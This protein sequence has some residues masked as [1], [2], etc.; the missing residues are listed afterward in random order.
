MAD[1]QLRWIVICAAVLGALG[2]VASLV[3]GYPDYAT[4]IAVGTVIALANLWVLIRLVQRMV[5]AGKAGSSA[6]LFLLKMLLLGGVLFACF[7][8]IP[9][10]T[11]GFTLGLSVIVIAVTLSAI[12]GPVPVD[13]AKDDGKAV[14]TE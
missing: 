6:G 5:H 3:A 13:P 9:M 4:G 12:F 8:L 2:V 1:H 7:K 11:I 10:D 14:E